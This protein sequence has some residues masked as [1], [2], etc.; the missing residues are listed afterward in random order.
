MRTDKTQSKLF[1]EY[2][3]LF[4]SLKDQPITYLEVGTA[5]GDSLVWAKNYFTTANLYGID[6]E[7]PKIIPEGV[8][9]TKIDQNDSEGLTLFGKEHG[10]FDIIIDDASHVR[11]ET[12]NTFNNLYPYLKI[13]GLYIIEDWGATYAFPEREMYKGLETLV[14]ELLFKYSGKIITIPHGGCYAII[15]KLG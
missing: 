13:G 9:F 1:C 3:E 2:E 4:K 11:K 6:I 5:Y 14:T 7:V 12:E 10:P 8:T 15:N